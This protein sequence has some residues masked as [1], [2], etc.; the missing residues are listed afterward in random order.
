[1]FSVTIAFEGFTW[2]FAFKTMDKAKA[3][4][5]SVAEARGLTNQATIVDDYGQEAIIEGSAIIG[6]LLADI[7]RRD[8]LAVDQYTRDFK[9]R[10]QAERLAMSGNPGVFM[11][12]MPR[13]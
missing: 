13:A 2:N 11:G 8:P 9:A 10:M 7:D 3:A 6:V 1:M 4:R 12:G 5:D